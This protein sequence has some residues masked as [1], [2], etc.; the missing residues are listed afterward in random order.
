MLYLIQTW[1]GATIHAFALRAARDAKLKELQNR[2][3]RTIYTAKETG[4]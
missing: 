4:Q 2:F 1:G 3:P